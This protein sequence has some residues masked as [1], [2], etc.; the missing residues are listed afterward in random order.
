MTNQPSHDSPPVLKS[1]RGTLRILLLAGIVG[2]V[3]VIG[4][5]ADFVILPVLAPFDGVQIPPYCTES[6]SHL[7]SSLNYAIPG[8]GTGTLLVSDAQSAV[9]VTAN[10]GGTPFSSTVYVINKSSN[11]I[12]RS[13][14]FS[15]D[16]IDATINDG[17]LYLFNDKLGYFLNATTGELL[18]FLVKADN[19][20]GLYTSGD[21]RWLQTSFEM[22]AIRSDGSL[23]SHLKLH[24][25]NIA[26]GCFFS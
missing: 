5:L 7:P 10:Y 19:Y 6:V 20:R 26:F 16:I 2:C 13:L 17:S 9:V 25:T 15:N 8:V 4:F 1:K 11:Q 3:A 22:S 23:I 14:T 12:V 24:F 21:P 18:P